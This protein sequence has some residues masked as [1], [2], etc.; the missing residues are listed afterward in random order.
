M[1]KTWKK[2]LALGMMAVMALS[3]TACGGKKESK[4]ETTTKTT[5]VEE[6]VTEDVT[7]EEATTEAE[8]GTEENIVEEGT[9]EEVAVA[10]E[11]EIQVQDAN[12]EVTRYA[13]TTSATILQDAMDECAGLYADFSYDGEAADWGFYLTT[14]NGLT[15][16]YDADGAYWSLYVNG[17]Y[18]SYGID[19]QPVNEGDVFLFA[20]EVY[21]AE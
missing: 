4:E 11:I 8:T 2:W 15:A 9:I 16:D 20:Y 18:G 5:V 7:T 13:V 19:S 21:Q 14:V 1:R 10:Q 12:G 3:V 6:A 17:E